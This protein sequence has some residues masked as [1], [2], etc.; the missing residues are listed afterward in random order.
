M[1]QTIEKII[2]PVDQCELF[3]TNANEFHCSSSNRSKTLWMA[4]ERARDRWG[5][6]SLPNLARAMRNLPPTE[7]FSANFAVEWLSNRRDTGLTAALY[8]TAFCH[9]S[10]CRLASK[11]PIDKAYSSWL[12]RTKSG[13]YNA[14]L[15]S[16]KRRWRLLHLSVFSLL[17]F[18]FLH[19]LLHHPAVLLFRIARSS[20]RRLSRSTQVRRFYLR[21]RNSSFLHIYYLTP[22]WSRNL[23]ILYS[24][25]SLSPFSA[26]YRSSQR[27][28][29]I[30]EK[31]KAGQRSC[32]R[33][34]ILFFS[35]IFFNV[36]IFCFKNTS[37][38]VSRI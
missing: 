32:T 6:S 3:G 21:H 13:D 11:Q 15:T 19:P 4:L 27:K 25:Y 18:A 38:R 22:A 24:R 17:L 36:D 2:A 35:L 29:K 33:A 31:E 28:K 30:M 26:W 5:I 7:T 34:I 16:C 9:P 23:Y 14:R 1:C 10:T 20:H 12:S 8:I 37:T